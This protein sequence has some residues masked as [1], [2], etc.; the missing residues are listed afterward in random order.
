MDY[1]KKLLLFSMMMLFE[2]RVHRGVNLE[3]K[4]ENEENK[5]RKKFVFFNFTCPYRDLGHPCRPYHH[6]V[7]GHSP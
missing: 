5:E 4:R 3:Q 6:Q 2:I 7:E 1:V